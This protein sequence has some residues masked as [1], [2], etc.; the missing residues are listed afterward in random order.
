[1]NIHGR[2]S[3]GVSVQQASA[4]VAAVTAQLAKAYPATNEFKAGIAGAY[5]PLGI[6]LRPQLRRIQTVGSPSL[7]WCCSSFR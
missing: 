5:D 4:A 7:A 6:L 3:P 1:V 2:L